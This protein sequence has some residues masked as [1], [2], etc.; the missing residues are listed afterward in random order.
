MKY[1]AVDRH[2][3]ILGAGDDQPLIV[4][5]LEAQNDEVNI[6]V[7]EDYRYVFQQMPNVEEVC[8]RNYV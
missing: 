5:Y 8:A 3:L 2:S 4:G 1:C 6:I 7:R